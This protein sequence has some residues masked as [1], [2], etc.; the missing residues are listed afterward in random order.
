MKGRKKDQGTWKNGESV[1]SSLSH[2]LCLLLPPSLRDPPP[3]LLL[4]EKTEITHHRL[5]P[6][7]REPQ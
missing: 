3:P 1:G 4:P 2:L 7:A 6:Q 5:C